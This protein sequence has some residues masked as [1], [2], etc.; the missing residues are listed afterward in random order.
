MI[1]L[2]E[3]LIR[4]PKEEFNH[5]FSRTYALSD[6]NLP[7]YLEGVQRGTLG[8]SIKFYYVKEELDNHNAK[9]DINASVLPLRD[10]AKFKV[11]QFSPQFFNSDLTKQAWFLFHIPARVTKFGLDLEQNSELVSPFWGSIPNII[12]KEITE[13]IP[14]PIAPYD[15][16]VA[17]KLHTLSFHVDYPFPDCVSLL[18]SDQ[19]FS[20]SFGKDWLLSVHPNYEELVVYYRD[21][22]VGLL[23][24]NKHN[25]IKVINPLFA[26]ELQDFL[27]RNGFMWK[28]EY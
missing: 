9:I 1:S 22:I 2:D 3:A 5:K 17:T 19:A 6:R 4:Y 21:I 7:I 25:I 16:D 8:I 12:R 28:V 18:A 26:Q 24:S 10:C 20:A 15:F 11:G 13:S 23:K 14:Y 27:N